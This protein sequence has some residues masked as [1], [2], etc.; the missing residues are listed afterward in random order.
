MEDE[1]VNTFAKLLEKKIE[2]IKYVRKVTNCG[3]VEA[4]V[5]VEFVLDHSYHGYDTEITDF[6]VIYNYM[7]KI[8]LLL[9]EGKI[10]LDNGTLIVKKDLSIN[11]LENM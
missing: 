4:K 10:D 1:C 9:K 6:M 7:I 5:T 2:M 11:D 8:G 3:L